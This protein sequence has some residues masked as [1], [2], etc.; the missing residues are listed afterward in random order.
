MPTPVQRR[1]DL[2]LIRVLAV[3]ALLLFHSGMPF[4]AEW[5]WHLKNAETS[6]LFLEW[7]NFMSTWRMSLLFFVSGAGTCLALRYRSANRYLR[8]RATRLLIPLAVGII[9]VVPPQIYFERLFNGQIESGYWSFWLTIFEGRPYPDG[10]TSWH[11]LWFILYLFIY[12]AMALPLFLALRR[13]S[14][15]LLDSMARSPSLSMLAMG[16]VYALTYALLSIPWPG[17]QNLVDDWGRFGSYF[18]LFVYGYVAFVHQG[19]G[20]ALY[21]SR[22][23]AFRLAFIALLVMNALRWNQVEWDWGLNL[24]SISYMTLRGL[25][26]FFWMVTILGFARQ[27][28]NKDRPWLA[29][30]NEAVY[31]FYILHQTVIVVLAYYVIQTSDTIGLKFPFLVT[32]SLVV[33]L[34]LYELFVRRSAWLRPLFGLKPLPNDGKLAQQRAEQERPVL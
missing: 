17:P 29:Y 3:L 31:P 19:L 13:V 27:F 33:T 10:N 14:G 2:D 12:S 6:N 23:L 20:D 24:P 32:A 9:L 22:H 21:R 4:V 1:H 34:G 18:V 28:L 5:G 26:G 15:T 11:H 7:M 8:E 16:L 25:C 30:A